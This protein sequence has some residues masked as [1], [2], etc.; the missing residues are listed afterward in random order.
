MKYLFSVLLSLFAI[1][2]M[3]QKDPKAKVVLDKVSAK[4]K[5]LTAVKANFTLKLSN[6]AGK[7]LGAKSGLLQVKG[8]KFRI[9]QGKDVIIN[10]GKTNWYYTNDANEVTVSKVDPTSDAFTP[11]KLF[12]NFYD[13]DFIYKKNADTKVGGKAVSEIELTPTNKNKNFFKVLLYIDNTTNLISGAKIYE[14]SGNIFDYIVSGLVQNPA[15]ADK[16]FI[17][18]KAEFPGVE[19]VD[20]D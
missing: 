11:Q 17:F 13:K 18:N 5:T 4:F 1:S 9:N 14:K 12:T 10:D 3:A 6:S 7:S 2:G 20:L 16:D 8:T 19:V 15:L